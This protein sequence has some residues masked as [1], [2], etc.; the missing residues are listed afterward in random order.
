MFTIGTS[1][2]E[3]STLAFPNVVAWG[4]GDA[5]AGRRSDKSFA[6]PP[7]RVRVRAHAG[8]GDARR[9]RR[10]RPSSARSTQPVQV[11]S[12][13]GDGGALA[14]GL[15]ALLHTIHRRARVTIFVLR[16][17]DL[18]QHRLPVQ[19][20]DDA[21][22]GDQHDARRTGRAR[23]TRARRS[24]TSTSPSPPART[25]SRRSARR[26]GSCSSSTMERALACE[27]TAVI[28][29]PAPVH[30]RLEIRG[31]P[32][33]PPGA[34][35]GAQP[36]CIPAFVWERGKGGSV[37]DC[38]L[39]PRRAAAARGVPRRAAPFPSP[40]GQEGRRRRFT[41]RAGREEDLVQLKAWTQ[42]NVERL[43]KLAELT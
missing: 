10:A 9:R 6:H 18:R 36:A 17:R 30:Q 14:I 2:A 31:R 43:Y 1:C 7:Q 4:R 29:V 24:T 8:R 3:V 39:D 33:D 34:E 37:K 5:A 13:S 41:A 38:A 12:A 16:E 42:K 35:L 15:R 27:G 20:G 11:I 22:R 40:G 26:T 28:F 25:W 23:A 21:L 19:P 32:D